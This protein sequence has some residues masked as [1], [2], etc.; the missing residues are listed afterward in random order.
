MDENVA[1]VLG[2]FRAVEERDREALLALYHDEIE[3]HDAESLPYGGVFR[4]KRQARERLESRTEE[5]WLGTWGP[6]QPS[7]AERRM[8]PRIVSSNDGEVVVAYHLR[9]VSATGERIDHPVVALYQVRDGKFARAQMFHFDT[10]ALAGF[11]DR[12][13]RATA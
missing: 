5:T 1:V 7:P 6:L 4:G 12:A 9:A 8:D 3:F 11:L 2:I 13:K 10:L